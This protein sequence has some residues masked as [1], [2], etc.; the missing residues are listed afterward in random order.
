MD[1]AL[2]NPYFLFQGGVYVGGSRLTSHDTGTVAEGTWW[3][4]SY[5]TR[6]PGWLDSKLTGFVKVRTVHILIAILWEWM[7]MLLFSKLVAQSKH[8]RI[9]WQ[10]LRTEFWA[11]SPFFVLL[12]F[13]LSK[14]LAFEK[15][16]ET[17]TQVINEKKGNTKQTNPFS[18][19]IWWTVSSPCR[20]ICWKIQCDAGI[21]EAISPS[22]WDRR[23]ATCTVPRLKARES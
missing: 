10:V 8:G 18:A 4:N 19:S 11:L 16:S 17:K 14:R 15:Y 7:D 3:S 5:R 13:C 22:W 9:D 6:D 23:N 21:V 1:K 2:L 20:G 12:D